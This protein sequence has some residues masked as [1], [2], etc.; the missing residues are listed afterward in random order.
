VRGDLYDPWSFRTVGR[1]DL[2]YSEISDSDALLSA[3]TRAQQQFEEPQA[4]LLLESLILAQ[5]E[6]WRRA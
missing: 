1:G 3:F 5:D 4:F 2:N 6:R